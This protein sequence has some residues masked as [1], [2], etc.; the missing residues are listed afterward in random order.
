MA[1][2]DHATTKGRV[3]RGTQT[4]HWY[5]A[6][7]EKSRTMPL[8]CCLLLLPVPLLNQ[9]RMP[10]PN[11][12]TVS[13]PWAMNGHSCWSGLEIQVVYI[14]IRFPHRVHKMGTPKATTPN[15]VTVVL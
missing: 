9:S 8:I 6:D 15:G 7:V 3:K 4:T 12:L 14:Q 10:D 2:D 11:G 13:S 5:G 1:P